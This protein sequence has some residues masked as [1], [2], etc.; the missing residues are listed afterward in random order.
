[1]RTPARKANRN[2]L[3]DRDA[4]GES[5]SA[6]KNTETVRRVQSVPDLPG[7]VKAHKSQRATSGSRG[8][9]LPPGVASSAVLLNMA[10]VM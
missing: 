7:Q 6:Q 1:M 3:A 2:G 5:C 10:M 9:I 4:H 8:A